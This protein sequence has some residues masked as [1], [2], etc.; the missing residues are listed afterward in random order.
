[1]L[2][3]DGVDPFLQSID[4][5]V[6]QA[7]PS[8][9]K[10]QSLRVVC[11]QY[12]SLWLLADR[13]NSLIGR[14]VNLCQSDSTS[15]F[16]LNVAKQFSQFAN[17]DKCR[18]WYTDNSSGVMKSYT[19]TGYEQR[20]L[21]NKGILGEVIKL[22]EHRFSESQ[23]ESKEGKENYLYK[24][25]NNGEKVRAKNTLLMP[26]SLS[27]IDNPIAVIEMSFRDSRMSTE[28]SYTALSLS[29]YVA[30]ML[31][32]CFNIELNKIAVK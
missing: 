23:S 8:L 20:V 30:R 27:D 18:L 25:L 10:V 2:H 3:I 6:G 31:L 24:L 28:D 14:L 13:L 12:L 11:N 21:S 7:G 32:N 9:A 4:T 22:K 29:Q 19:E 5:K 1:M 16:S 15:S 26:I 17:I